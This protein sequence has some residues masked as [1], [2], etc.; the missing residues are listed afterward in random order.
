VN[1]AS[2]GEG[3]LR[4]TGLAIRNLRCLES[5]SLDALAP[6]NLF[7]GRNGSGKT[8]MLEA[9][10]LLSIGKSFQVSKSRDLIRHGCDALSVTGRIE[11]APERV[12]RVGVS[13]TGGETEVSWNGARLSSASDLAE[14]VP[15]IFVTPDSIDIV[16]GGPAQR[17]R[18]LDKTMFHVEPAFASVFKNFQRAAGQRAAL[19]R[20]TTDPAAH[21]F[22]HATLG[23]TAARLD[24]WRQS[25]CEALEAEI[26]AMD[27]PS[28]LPE[29]ALEYKRGWPHG[30]E[31]DA[32]L[33]ESL[34]SDRRTGRM[35]YGPQRAEIRFSC[36]AGD[37][38]SVFSRGQA[39]VVA[40]AVLLAQWQIIAAA[41]GRRPIILFDDLGAELAPDF[42][43]WVCR[44]LG[45]TRAQRFV[46]VTERALIDQAFLEGDTAV[47]HVEHGAA[48]RENGP[49]TGRG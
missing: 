32:L 7:Y 39:R 6:L 47:F 3:S 31:L 48:H 15:M 13:K 36:E 28:G 9:I 35:A 25:A 11:V 2:S 10:G 41:S 22:W 23:E 30:R 46:T 5:T 21:A 8:S 24:A 37:V 16:R 40:T 29:I 27:W 49:L 17:R 18:V 43:T 4:V 34:D 45:E 14:R 1:A 38:R 33:A 20:R 26:R 19:L 42:R 44:Q 12:A